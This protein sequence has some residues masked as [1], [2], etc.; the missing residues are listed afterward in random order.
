M[1]LKKNCASSGISMNENEWTTA[2]CKE[3][4]KWRDAESFPSTETS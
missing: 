2:M 1:K 4:V 3:T